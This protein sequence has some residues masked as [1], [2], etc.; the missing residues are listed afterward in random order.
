M[1][2]RGGCLHLPTESSLSSG[3]QGKT[4]CGPLPCCLSC[5][6]GSRSWSGDTDARERKQHLPYCTETPEAQAGTWHPDLLATAEHLCSCWATGQVVK[7]QWEGSGVSRPG[8]VLLAFNNG[9]S[10]A[11]ARVAGRVR[12]CFLCP[13]VW[14]RR[15]RADLQLPM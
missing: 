15:V 13:C 8:G 12:I 4:G 14:C 2:A 1:C 7:G 11:G 6:T 10:G 3:S 5:R 9:I